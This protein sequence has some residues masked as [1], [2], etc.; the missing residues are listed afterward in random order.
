M[1]ADQLIVRDINDLKAGDVFNLIRE[2]YDSSDYLSDDFYRKFKGPEGFIKHHNRILSQAG[3]FILVALF[4]SS[5]VGY[6]TLEAN[7]AAHLRHTSLLNMGILKSFRGKGV[8][9]FLLEK[10]TIRAVAEQTIEII[11]LMVRAE[12]TPAI[13]L[14]KGA[15]FEK[16]VRLEKDTKIGTA[17]YD[18]ILMRKFL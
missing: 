13:R 3:S 16:L 1:M 18:G 8:G 10:S 14:Y 15:G 12:N 5:P 2:V 11:Y 17:Y 4:E 7:R 9:K 6:L